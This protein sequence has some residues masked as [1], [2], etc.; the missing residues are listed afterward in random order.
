M[1]SMML[2]LVL[3]DHQHSQFRAIQRLT[4]SSGSSASSAE[5]SQFL[6]VDELSTVTSPN[7]SLSEG[8]FCNLWLKPGSLSCDYLIHGRIIILY[9]LHSGVVAFLMPS[10]LPPILALSTSVSK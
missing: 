4:L 8:T 9:L 7:P 1:T 5:D 10:L 2:L 6:E 3:T